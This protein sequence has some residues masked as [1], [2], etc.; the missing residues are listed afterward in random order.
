MLVL[1][2]VPTQLQDF[3][4]FLAELQEV[5][6][7]L[8]SLLRSFWMAAQSCGVVA[9]PSSFEVPV[10]WQRVNSVLTIQVMKMLYRIGPSTDPWVT[11]LATGL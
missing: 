7:H 9:T 2:V 10:S 4:L 5:P 3:S 8:S 11:L 6:V 1:G